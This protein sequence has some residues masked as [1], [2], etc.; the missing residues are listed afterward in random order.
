MHGTTALHMLLVSEKSRKEHAHASLQ[1][2]LFVLQFQEHKPGVALPP[3]T[4]PL[5]PPEVLHV[6]STSDSHVYDESGERNIITCL[7]FDKPITL[8][9]AHD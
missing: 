1:P 4:R 9:V 7:D 8:S 6:P 2:A 3:S 5:A